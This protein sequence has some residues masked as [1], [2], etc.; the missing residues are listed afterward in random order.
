MAERRLPPNMSF[1]WHTGTKSF[2]EIY[3]NPLG[4]GKQRVEEWREA[5]PP[6]Q[7]SEEVMR[8][9]FYKAIS[10]AQKMPDR[11][12]GYIR[13]DIEGTEETENN[14]PFIMDTS[15]RYFP[16]AEEKTIA[17]EGYTYKAKI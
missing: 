10:L 15:P 5:P 7:L 8:F 1:V 2:A 16:G 14:R 3:S 4:G 11:H 17:Y 12:V 13:H 9:L 6:Q